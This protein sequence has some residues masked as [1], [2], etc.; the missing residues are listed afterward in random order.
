MRKSEILNTRAPVKKDRQ[1]NYIVSYKLKSKPKILISMYFCPR[2][3]KGCAINHPC[4][5]VCSTFK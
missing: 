1:D 3:V 2:A 5:K 4:C